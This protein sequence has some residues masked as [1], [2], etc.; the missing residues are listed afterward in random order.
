VLND[1]E[2]REVPWDVSVPN[3]LLFEERL[4][5]DGE[6]PDRSTYKFASACIDEDDESRAFTIDLHDA[7]RVWAMTNGEDMAVSRKQLMEDIVDY[8]SLD[9]DED[10]TRPTYTDGTRKNAWKRIC[11]NERGLDY[12]DREDER[13]NLEEVA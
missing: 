13:H 7:Y 1:E 4:D 6:E 9:K 10:K 2:M 3:R 8:Y 5:V 11:L 12:L